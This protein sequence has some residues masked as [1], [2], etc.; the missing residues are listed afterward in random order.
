MITQLVYSEDR[1]IYFLY[2]FILIYVHACI[3][4]YRTKRQALITYVN[5]ILVLMLHMQITQKKGNMKIH[6]VINVYEMLK[7]CGY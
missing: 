1:I 5:N 3:Y 6:F 2:I 4:T 7:M